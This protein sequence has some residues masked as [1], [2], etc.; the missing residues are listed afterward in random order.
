MEG[1]EDIKRAEVSI[2]Y[3]FTF[4][5]SLRIYRFVLQTYWDN[6]ALEPLTVELSAQKKV[7]IGSNQNLEGLQRDLL[8]LMLE[9][10]RP[11]PPYLRGGGIRG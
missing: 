3:M 4:M 5:V 7:H 2:I 6:S 9:Q 10:S 1:R 11:H 8:I